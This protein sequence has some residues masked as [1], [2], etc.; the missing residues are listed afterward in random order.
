VREKAGVGI[1]P[2]VDWGKAGEEECALQL[3]LE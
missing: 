2:G 3:R 1:A